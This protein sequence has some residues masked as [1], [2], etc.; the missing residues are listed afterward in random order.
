MTM[1]VMILIRPVYNRTDDDGNG[2]ADGAVAIC[3]TT[4]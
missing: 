4:C 1:A 3:M 2:D